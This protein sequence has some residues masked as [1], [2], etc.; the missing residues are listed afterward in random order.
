MPSLI[1]SGY[2]IQPLIKT[3]LYVYWLGSKPAGLEVRATDI[4]CLFSLDWVKLL[5]IKNNI[6]SSIL[7]CFCQ[8][9]DGFVLY[10]V[11]D[12]VY[13][14]RIGRS[15]EAMPRKHHKHLIVVYIEWISIRF[16]CCGYNLVNNA[17]TDTIKVSNSTPKQKNSIRILVGVQAC[18]IGSK[19]NRYTM[20]IFIGLGQIAEYQKSCNFFNFALF[21][22]NLKMDL[23]YI[24][25]YESFITTG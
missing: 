19:S 16:C 12:V 5:N 20:S 17:I 4:P 7:F 11:L 2:Q 14:Y 8:L 24:M 21:F 18:W 23:C 25:F 1:R 3:F 10:Y 9:K 15:M 22:V 13:Y 6:T